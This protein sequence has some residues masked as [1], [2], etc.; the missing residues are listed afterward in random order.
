MSVDG[1]TALPDGRQLKL[2]SDEDMARV[3][4]LRHESD[5]VLVGVGT[6]L[7]DDPKLTVKERYV[8]NPRQPLRVILDSNCR[9]P[10]NAL[11][12]NKAAKTI[13]F[14]KKTEQYSFDVSHVCIQKVDVDSDGYLDLNIILD[15]L[16]ERGIRQLLVEGGGRV[17]WSFISQ[18]LIDRLYVYIAPVIIG[19]QGTPLF[20]DGKGTTLFN[21]N[22]ALSLI[23]IKQVG[24]GFLLEYT[25]K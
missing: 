19:G 3:Y 9:I 24:E 7:S 11:I 25:V 23:D 22:I 18:Y 13:I 4:R 14:T 17:I 2:S 12:F 8:A 5:A 20:A 10:E 15:K 16:Y 1:K 6:V 21:E